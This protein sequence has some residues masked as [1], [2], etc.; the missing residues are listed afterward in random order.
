[1]DDSM[2]MDN[3]IR[4]SAKNA[5]KTLKNAQKKPLWLSILLKILKQH[6][7]LFKTVSKRMKCPYLELISC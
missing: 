5:F 1:M 4:H 7:K 3:M 2:N 6:S